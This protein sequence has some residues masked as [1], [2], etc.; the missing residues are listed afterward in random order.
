LSFQQKR[1]SGLEDDT[2]LYNTLTQSVSRLSELNQTY[3]KKAA[4][5]QLGELLDK[6]RVANVA[7][8]EEPTEPLSAAFP[9]RGL[10]LLVGFVWSLLAGAIAALVFD[11][12]V[13]RVQS[14]YDAELALEAPVIA[15][16][17]D[18]MTAP[19]Y[20]E[21]NAAVYRALQRR[22]QPVWRLM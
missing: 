10:V 20:S 8:V 15:L 5:A 14:P 6:K 17:S 3:E 11:L 1:L 13:R 16:F 9:R 18:G 4:D 12:L 21:A 2:A 22:S 7:V 19:S